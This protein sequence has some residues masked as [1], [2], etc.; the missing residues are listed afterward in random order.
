MNRRLLQL[1]LLAAALGLTAVSHAQT[2]ITG[3]VSDANIT[4]GSPNVVTSTLT[5]NQVGFGGSSGAMGLNT[6]FVFELPKLP[7][8]QVFTSANFHLY[9]GGAVTSG[10]Y[11]PN[12]N[13]DLYGLQYR[14]SDA[15]QPSDWFMGSNDTANTKIQD[16]FLLST[17][18]GV[19]GAGLDTDAT[20]DTQL[21]SYL[22]RQ[23]N[24]SSGT[25]TQ[26]VYI[27]LRLNPDL[28]GRTY[29]YYRIYSAE[30][31]SFY[32][33]KITYTTG[34]APQRFPQPKGFWIKD[35]STAT[36]DVAASDYTNANSDVSKLKRQVTT[37][38]APSINYN[39]WTTPVWVADASTPK[40]PIKDS[41][42]NGMTSDWTAVPWPLNATPNDDQIR[43]EYRDL[44]NVI[45]DS[46]ADKIYEFIGCE[47]MP[48]ATDVSGNLPVAGH[49]PYIA[50]SH[51]GVASN[52]STWNGVFSGWKG[53]TGTGLS[54]IG[55]LITLEEAQR[56]AAD[57]TD[58]YVIP[59]A[60]AIAA[61]AIT[62]GNF[63]S[64]AA[65]SDAAAYGDQTYVIAE[66]RRFRLKQNFDI[67]TQLAGKPKI[68][69]AIAR[70][71]QKYGMVIRDT[72]GAVVFYGEDA[73]SL[74]AA[75]NPWPAATEGREG[76][77]IGQRFPWDQL[78][79][80]KPCDA[81]GNELP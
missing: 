68:V 17:A 20:G 5:Q 70:A 74:P 53:A 65:R 56:I 55:G 50:A 2:T 72:S 32:Q 44:H 81:N 16:N 76:W 25:G 38:Y 26:P 60:I 64:P 34:P 9:H 71:V 24:Q 78:E 51:G 31:T 58:S 41:N 15:V 67:N 79:V 22:N 75:D 36:V 42:D 57:T 47:G 30:N 69:R 4:Q 59:H 39:S 80:I 35:V 61:K 10:G 28:F 66:G 23:L 40:I 62:P 3:R 19:N 52:A 1:P 73:R 12:Y 21:V 11:G 37:G 54:L 8:G 29:T 46:A 33:P 49:Y 7:A 43:T 14:L 6:V 77:Y 13:G 63:V 45:Y 27:F 18:I 48:N